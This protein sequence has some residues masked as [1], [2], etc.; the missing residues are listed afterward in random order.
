MSYENRRHSTTWCEFRPSGK[1]ATVKL[2]M[3][4]IYYLVT[5]SF[6]LQRL[7]N[8]SFSTFPLMVRYIPEITLLLISAFPNY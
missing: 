7:D 4:R 6:G 3:G 1:I 5:S 8:N 2:W